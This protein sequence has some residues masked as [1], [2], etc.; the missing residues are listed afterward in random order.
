MSDN[1][2]T[3]SFTE[4]PSSLP[5]FPLSGA[6]LL[7]HGEL[8]LNIFEPRYLSMVLDALGGHRMIGMVQPDPRAEAAPGAPEAVYPCGCAGRITAFRETSDGRLL[9]MLTGI[10][11]FRVTS[12]LELLRGYRRVTPEWTAFRQDLDGE[13]TDAVDVAGLIAAVKEYC[14]THG[15]VL[16]WDGL[17][18]FPAPRLVDFLGVNLPFGPVEKQA[19]VEAAGVADRA[20]LLLAFTQMDLAAGNGRSDTRH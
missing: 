17:R 6:I 15:L 12:E 19:L 10:C 3:P 1:P 11:R 20:R 4:L 14:A 13:Q 5:I 16:E 7:P 9:I 2:F 8:P 18:D